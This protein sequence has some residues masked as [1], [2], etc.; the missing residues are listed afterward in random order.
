L[1]KRGVLRARKKN[2][3]L[4]RSRDEGKWAAVIVK[5][6]VKGTFIVAALTGREQHVRRIVPYKRE[7]RGQQIPAVQRT[8]KERKGKGG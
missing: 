3:T 2:A 4:M 8:S 1:A 5:K 7:T 6:R